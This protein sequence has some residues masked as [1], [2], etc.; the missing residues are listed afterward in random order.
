M[1]TRILIVDD[2]ALSREVLALLLHGAGYEVESADSGNAALLHLQT[3]QPLPQVV[4]TDLQMPGT[5]GDELSR[6]LRTLCGPGTLLMAMSASV[7]GDGSDEGFDAFLLKPFTVETFAAAIAG[8]AVNR[9]TEEFGTAVLDD[10]VYK[11]LAA[12]MRGSQLEQLFLLCLSDAESRLKKMRRAASDGDADTYVREAHALKGSSGM[13]G[14][15]Q[16]QTLAT[17]METEGLSD[18]HVVSLNEFVVAC[19]RLRRMLVANRT[20]QD[21]PAVGQEKTSDEGSE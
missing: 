14:A 13:V 20:I 4:L 19:E 15:L 11:K 1:A 9:T 5:S 18:D 12:S 17:S 10:T 21:R 8:E 3:A 2:D 16:L 6:Q 7:P